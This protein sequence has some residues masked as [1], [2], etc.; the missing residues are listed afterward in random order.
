MVKF[1]WINFTFIFDLTK[2]TEE[3][4]K[5]KSLMILKQSKFMTIF[6]WLFLFRF[7]QF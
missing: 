3:K 7:Y 6:E 1:Q 2:N 5:R 4:E